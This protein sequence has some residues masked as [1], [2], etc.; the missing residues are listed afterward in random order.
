MNFSKKN[1]SLSRHCTQNQSTIKCTLCKTIIITATFTLLFLLFQNC[2]VDVPER[3]DRPPKFS[4]IINGDGLDRTFDQDDDF[5]RL[6]LNLRIGQTY[7]FAYIV[8]DSGGLKQV[9]YE[10]VRAE[11]FNFDSP[12]ELPWRPI[13]VEHTRR[14]DWLGDSENPLNGVVLQGSFEVLGPSDVGF[15]V[16]AASD[17]GGTTGARN[18][19][20]KTLTISV[21]DHVTEVI[22]L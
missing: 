8:S 12:I 18:S 1:H 21:D 2:T 9:S 10:V 14:V 13:Y 5:E 4:F 22:N 16:F 7:Q 17:Y 3:D 20:F 6:K 15:F 11:N 19:V